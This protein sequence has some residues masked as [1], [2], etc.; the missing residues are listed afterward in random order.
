MS[1]FMPPSPAGRPIAYVFGDPATIKERGTEIEELGQMMLD[2]A[3]QLQALADGSDG[4]KGKAVEK[5]DA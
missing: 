3:S 1:M 2:S 4:L 5:H